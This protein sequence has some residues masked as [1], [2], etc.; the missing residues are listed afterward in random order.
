LEFPKKISP[1]FIYENLGTKKGLFL[2]HFFI[3][4]FWGTEHRL[5]FENPACYS[6]IKRGFL[7]HLDI[8]LI[9]CKKRPVF[10]TF[11]K[12]FHFGVKPRDERGSD[13]KPQTLKNQA[14]LPHLCQYFEYQ[15][16]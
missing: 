16:Y 9:W 2:P 8:I 1:N 12:L 14:K 11:L 3:E 13:A 4:R 10:Y 15:S 7:H 6:D 5:F